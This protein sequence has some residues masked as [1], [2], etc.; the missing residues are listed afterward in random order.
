M[1]RNYLN[2][3]LPDIFT[4]YNRNA[5]RVC[6]LDK[7]DKPVGFVVR[8]DINK[9]AMVIT[10]PR[11]SNENIFGWAKTKTIHLPYSKLIYLLGVAL[12]KKELHRSAAID[13]A[14]YQR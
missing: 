13:F 7:N 3:N 12:P 6:V 1:I 4:S 11:Q 5:H 10:N 14:C 2:P 9:E 8:Y